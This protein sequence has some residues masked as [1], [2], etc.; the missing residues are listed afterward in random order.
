MLLLPPN[1]PDAQHARRFNGAVEAALA[2]PEVAQA[3]EK[4]MPA[5]PALHDLAIVVEVSSTVGCLLCSHGAWEWLLLPAPL[6]AWK[7][8]AA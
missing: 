6:R 2:A 7:A 4:A 1:F 8:S 3:L 5:C